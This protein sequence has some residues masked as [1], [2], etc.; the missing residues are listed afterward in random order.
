M[1]SRAILY[2]VACWGS[3][4]M[5]ADANKLSKLI[6]RTRDVVG[7]EIDGGV[8]E[9]DAVQ[10]KDTIGQ[11]LHLCHDVLI[12]HFRPIQQRTHPPVMHI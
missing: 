8:R 5:L 1:T 9:E 11:P 2:A 7:M 6:R 3:R 4:L 10:V 12:S